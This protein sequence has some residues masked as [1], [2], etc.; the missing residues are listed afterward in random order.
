MTTTNKAKAKQPTIDTETTVD[1]AHSLLAEASVLFE[2]RGCI[3][4]CL[5]DNDARKRFLSIL[6]DVAHRN[7]LE[8]VNAA[9]R[10]TKDKK[11]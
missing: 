3:R 7:L 8:G 5:P 11:Q 9:I 6:A 2:V 4:M 1:K 10:E